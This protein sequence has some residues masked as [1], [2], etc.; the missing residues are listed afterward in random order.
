[1]VLHL[2]GNA[3]VFAGPE[4]FNEYSHRLIC[5]S[6]DHPDR[7]RAAADFRAAHLQ[8]GADVP[9]E[10]GGTAASLPDEGDRRPHQP[11]A[12]ASSTMIATGLLLL[13]FVVVHVK[14]FKFGSYYET[15]GDSAIRDLYR[16][17]IEVFQ[18]PF[19]VR[20]TSSA[21]SSSGCTCATASPA[22]SSRS[23]ST[24]RSTRGG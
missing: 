5:E 16:T 11:Q 24:T 12:L 19:W 8:G 18:Q 2:A 20:S 22:A 9:G 14:Q 1:M 6:A 7:D 21:R 23:G 17:E 15:V 10:Q 4:I 3:I 13:L